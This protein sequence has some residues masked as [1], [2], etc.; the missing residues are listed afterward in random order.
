MQPNVQSLLLLQCIIPSLC[1]V[2]IRTPVCAGVEIGLSNIRTGFDRDRKKTR[3]RTVLVL[4][5]SRL[6]LVEYREKNAPVAWLLTPLLWK[7]LD[8]SWHSEHSRLLHDRD[9]GVLILRLDLGAKE[10]KLKKFLIMLAGSSAR[11]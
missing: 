1:T 2:L 9:H 11:V 4:V 7:L 6:S 3:E 5:V 10:N 8:A